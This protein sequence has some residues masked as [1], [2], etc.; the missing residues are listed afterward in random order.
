LGRRKTY[1]RELKK[2]VRDGA[3]GGYI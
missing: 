1:Q 2:K 3:E